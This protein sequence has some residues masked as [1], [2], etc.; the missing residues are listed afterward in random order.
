MVI[1]WTLIQRDTMSVH[2]MHIGGAAFVST[3]IF[4]YFIDDSGSD[5]AVTPKNHNMTGR[6]FNNYDMYGDRLDGNNM[7]TNNVDK[8]YEDEVSHQSDLKLQ[9]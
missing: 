7:N 1:L 6:D 9:L 5:L 3:L 2:W 4:I 8:F